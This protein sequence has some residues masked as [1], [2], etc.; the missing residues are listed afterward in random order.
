MGGLKRQEGGLKQREEMEKDARKTSPSSRKAGRF[1]GG[2]R[3]FETRAR[4]VESTDTR[5]WLTKWED[6]R[7][8]M[9]ATAAFGVSVGGDAS[10]GLHLDDPMGRL[11]FAITPS[12]VT[13]S[14]VSQ[15]L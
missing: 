6:S 13:R 5:Q 7:R 10:G 4:R 2:P 3:G 8:E 9:P 14:P 11:F 1:S 12:L 15:C